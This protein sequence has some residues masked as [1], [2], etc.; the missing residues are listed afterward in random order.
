LKAIGNVRMQQGDS[1]EMNS[2]KL[3]YDGNTKL[4]RAWEQ[5]DL[6]DG[7]MTLTT[8][9]L[10]FDRENLNNWTTIEFQKTPICTGH[11]Q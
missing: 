4:A 11:Q 6:T 2:G 1:V 10:Y 3:D 8:D 9:T 7:Q 5:V